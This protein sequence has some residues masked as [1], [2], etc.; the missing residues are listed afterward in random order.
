[1]ENA[2]CNKTNTGDGNGRVSWGESQ[3][4]HRDEGSGTFVSLRGA[5]TK[6]IVCIHYLAKTDD[7]NKFSNLEWCHS[8]FLEILANRMV[9]LLEENYSSVVVV[10]LLL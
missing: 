5:K 8:N 9:F 10:G 1:M 7:V 2:I 6:D 4:T 3:L